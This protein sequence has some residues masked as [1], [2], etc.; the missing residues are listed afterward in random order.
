MLD[1]FAKHNQSLQATAAQ[2]TKKVSASTPNVMTAK[3]RPNFDNSDI[4]YAF[5]PKIWEKN[6]SP[7]PWH[8][9]PRP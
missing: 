4:G 6:Y 9:V 1:P 2:A 5:Q 7:V 8:D 3:P